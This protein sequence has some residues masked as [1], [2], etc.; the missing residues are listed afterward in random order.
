MTEYVIVGV[1]VVFSLNE[2]L[3]LA[4]DARVKE[5]FLV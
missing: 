4:R 3:W 5:R 2:A 1:Y